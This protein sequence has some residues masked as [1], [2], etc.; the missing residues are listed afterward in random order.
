MKPNRFS[1]QTEWVNY[2]KPFHKDKKIKEIQ[3][4]SRKIK[5]KLENS[6]IKPRKAERFQKICINNGNL[7]NIASEESYNKNKRIKN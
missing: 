3:E 2:L 7:A 6:H 5:F 1:T 4:I